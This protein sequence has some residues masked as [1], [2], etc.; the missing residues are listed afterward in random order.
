MSR[1]FVVLLSI[2]LKQLNS[3]T[4]SNTFS[5][6]GGREVTHRTAV[7]GSIMTSVVMFAFYALVAFLLFWCKTSYLT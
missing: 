5:C 1:K 3:L 6:L 4:L 7:P 2:A